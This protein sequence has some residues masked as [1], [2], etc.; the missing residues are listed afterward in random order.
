MKRMNI[1]TIKK[2]SHAKRLQMMTNI[3]S[4]KLHI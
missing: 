3:R 1:N 4:E 2:N